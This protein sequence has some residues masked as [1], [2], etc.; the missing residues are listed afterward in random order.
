MNV[1]ESYVFSFCYKSISPHSQPQLDGMVFKSPQNKSFT[2]RNAR[3]GLQ[4]FSRS[5]NSLVQ[6]LPFLPGKPS[7]KI[8]GCFIADDG[9]MEINGT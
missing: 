5:L 1:I 3:A 9:K 7:L 2:I 4:L 6:H 8:S